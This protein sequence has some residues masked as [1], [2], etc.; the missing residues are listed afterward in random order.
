MELYKRQ[1]EVTCKEIWLYTKQ[2]FWC[3]CIPLRPLVTHRL[4]KL[5]SKIFVNKKIYVLTDYRLRRR[6]SW[7][8]TWIEAPRNWQRQKCF[9]TLPRSLMRSDTTCYFPE[10][11]AVVIVCVGVVVLLSLQLLLLL[12]LLLFFW[13]PLLLLFLLF[14]LLLLFILLV[15]CRYIW[16]FPVSVAAAAVAADVVL[17]CCCYCC[18]CCC[19]SCSCFVSIKLQ[20][21]NT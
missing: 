1:E 18:H 14:M 7:N 20:I 17:H 19:S 6:P 13:Q 4:R 8:V 10:L 11:K 16:F 12:L 2:I 21:W 5:C 3:Y 9:T 15:F